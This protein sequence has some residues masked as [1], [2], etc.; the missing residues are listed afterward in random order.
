MVTTRQQTALA[1]GIETSCRTAMKS[2]LHDDNRSTSVQFLSGYMRD[3]APAHLS[4]TRDTHQLRF[5]AGWL[6]VRRYSTGD[7]SSEQ[8]GRISKACSHELLGRR[9]AR[10]YGSEARLLLQISTHMLPHR[11]QLLRR[12]EFLIY[13]PKGFHISNRRPFDEIFVVDTRLARG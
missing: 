7:F 1:L 8:L 13:P 5:C 6:L 9:I 10:L 2:R 4:H 12:E 3:M 11:S